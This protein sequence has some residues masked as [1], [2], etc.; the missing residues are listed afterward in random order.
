M[1]CGH[2]KLW[3][4]GAGRLGMRE[5]C[6]EARDRARAAARAR[7]SQPPEADRQSGILQLLMLSHGTNTG[8]RGQHLKQIDGLAHSALSRVQTTLSRRKPSWLALQASHMICSRVL[9]RVR[10]F[11]SK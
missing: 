2:G 6:R 11:P 9:C 10:C 3:W 1:A 5:G 4:K 8:P 7:A